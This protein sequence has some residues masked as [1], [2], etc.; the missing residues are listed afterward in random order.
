MRLGVFPT[1]K[2]LVYCRQLNAAYRDC[3]PVCNSNVP[4]TI[5]HLLLDCP[6]WEM[7]RVKHFAEL[8]AMGWLRG[9][10]NVTPAELNFRVSFRV[11]AGVLLGGEQGIGTVIEGDAPGSVVDNSANTSP[12]SGAGCTVRCARFLGEVLPIRRRLV[13]P[14]LESRGRTSSWNQGPMGTVDLQ[15]L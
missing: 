4:E 7:L 1:G 11:S 8:Y 10:R 14:K 6:E 2:R 9:G 13:A 15:D 12:I 3:C 5:E